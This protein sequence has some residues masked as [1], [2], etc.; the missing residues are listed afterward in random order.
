[1][2]SGKSM[3]EIGYIGE[4]PVNSRIWS[5][6]STHP[7]EQKVAIRSTTPN[8]LFQYYQ[9]QQQQHQQQQQQL[10]PSIPRPLAIP[11][12]QQ[13]GPAALPNGI[14]QLRLR[15]GVVI[16]MT[17]DKSLKLINS[18]ENVTI[19][20]SHNGT[21]TALKHPNGIVFQN[22]PKV[23]IVAYDGRRNNSYV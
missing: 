15:D 18:Q 4:L 2:R 5:S 3:P 17:I 7:L 20:L 23:D 10:I 13:F 11:I 16:E 8:E 9:Q 19:A 1:M 12:V 14:I 21:L 22:G 6:I